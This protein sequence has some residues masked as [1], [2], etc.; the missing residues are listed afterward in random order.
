MPGQAATHWSSV[1]SSLATTWCRVDLSSSTDQV[2]SIGG[3]AD[4]PTQINF[5]NLNAAG[6]RQFRERSP[7]QRRRQ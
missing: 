5:E 1:E 3:V 2:V 6:A 7:R 4:A